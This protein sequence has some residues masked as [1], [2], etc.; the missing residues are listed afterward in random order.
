MDVLAPPIL[1]AASAILC[2]AC[3]GSC[4]FK[5]QLVPVLALGLV[6][7]LMRFHVQ[8]PALPVLNAAAAILC[9]AFL[10]P[11]HLNCSWCRF[12]LWVWFGLWVMSSICCCFCCC[13]F[14][15]GCWCNYGCACSANS[16]CCFCNSMCCL[17]CSCAFKLQLVPLLALGLVGLRAMSSICFCVCWCLLLLLF[18]LLFQFKG[19]WCNFMRKR[20]P[21]QFWKGGPMGN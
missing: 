9:A 14:V 1:D 5:L 16:G 17:S 13:F 12:L 8:V 19:C 15:K 3:V 7:A 18:W 11:A 6:R 4:A 20:L 10:V 2:A 21:C